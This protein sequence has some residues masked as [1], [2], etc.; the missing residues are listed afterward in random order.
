[1]VPELRKIWETGTLISHLNNLTGDNFDSSNG[2]NINPLTIVE[3]WKD[4]TPLHPVFYND[5]IAAVT[6]SGHRAILSAPWYL[7]RVTYGT[8]PL[9][10]YQMIT[11]K[12]VT[13]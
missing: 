3:V 10:F 13:V 4:Y 6:K 8:R 5:T 1:M 7:S 11:L 12:T 2:V 9:C